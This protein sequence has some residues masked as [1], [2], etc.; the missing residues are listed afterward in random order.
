MIKATIFKD[1]LPIVEAVGNTKQEAEIDLLYQLVSY[2]QAISL[3][4]IDN[5]T[6]PTNNPTKELNQ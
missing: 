5:P 2:N 4:I 6:I 3:Q 1:G